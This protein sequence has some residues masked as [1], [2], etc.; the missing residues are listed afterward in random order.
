LRYVKSLIFA[1]LVT[2]TMA[3]AA[4]IS[5]PEC[6]AAGYDTSGCELLITV[7]AASG[8][9]ATAFTVTASSP[10][11]GPYDGADDTL[12]G[13]LN[14]SGASLASVAL[15]SSTDIFGFDGD[16]VCT[17]ISCPGATDPSG[18]A[19][20]GV[21]FS[22]VNSAETSGT[23]NFNPAIANGGTAFFSL[24]E[25]LT[26]S[27]ITSGTPEPSTTILLGIGIAGLGLFLRRAR[28]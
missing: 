27:Q 8:G 26:P 19:P 10:D 7:T 24:E 13:V 28:A 12:I 16:G 15:S 20:A 6:P 1:A 25:A 17:Y 5:F 2:G 3:Q 21:T 9:F 22:G 14:N 4:S 11:L 18:Y 23:V